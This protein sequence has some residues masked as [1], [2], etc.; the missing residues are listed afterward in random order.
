[1]LTIV[2]TRKR[3]FAREYQDWYAHPL[4]QKKLNTALTWWIEK[5]GI[6]RKYDKVAGNMDC[7]KECDMN[8]ETDEDSDEVLGDYAL[9]MQHSQQNAQLQQQLQQQQMTYAQLQGQCMIACNAN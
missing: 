8:T 2:I 4:P 7:G 3:L 9:S 6:M 1:M 5:V